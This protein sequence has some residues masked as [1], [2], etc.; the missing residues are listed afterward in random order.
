V[1]GQVEYAIRVFNGTGVAADERAAAGWFRRAAE[2]GNPVAANR[3]ARILMAG[4]GLPADPV[5]AA[6]WHL[7]A[8]SAGAT[9]ATLDDFVAGLSEDQRQ[10]ARLSPVPP[11][12]G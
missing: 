7:F 6:R 8:A 11:P 1:P 12:N 2:A 4:R 10:A 9:D 3:L 5:E